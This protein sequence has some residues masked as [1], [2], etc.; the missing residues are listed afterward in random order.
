MGDIRK[1]H[2]DII[3]MSEIIP[4]NVLMSRIYSA[5]KDE[6]IIIL[7]GICVIYDRLDG[8][9]SQIHVPVVR[10]EDDAMIASRKSRADLLELR[11]LFCFA[12]LFFQLFLPDQLSL[13]FLL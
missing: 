3:I 2:P 13:A 9:I 5:V 8:H 6:N 1:T 4:V 7:R 10:T 12:N 11:L